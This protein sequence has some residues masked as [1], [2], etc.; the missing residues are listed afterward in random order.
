MTNWK[1][2]TLTTPRLL[3]RPW[4]DSDAE[5]LYRFASDPQV[6][7]AAGWPPHTSIENSREII[8]GVLS[9]RETYAMILRYDTHDTIN[10]EIIPAGTPVGSVGIMFKGCGSYPRLRDNEAEIGYWVARPL[11]G[12]ELAPEAVWAIMGRCFEELGLERLW[13]GF[14]EGNQ[15]SRRVQQ[16]C[17]FLTE[18]YLGIPP[19]PLNGATV[20]Y[21]TSVNRYRWQDMNARPPATMDMTLREAPFR[22]VASGQKRVELRLYDCKRRLLRV[23]DF[24]HF[25]LEEGQESCHVEVTGIRYF[26]SFEALYAELLPAMGAA[27]LGYAEGEIPHPDDMLAYYTRESINFHGVVAI[28][29]K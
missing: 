14:Y 9:A 18:T 13:C 20:E 19:H 24:I 23:G 11:W 29:I 25:R 12:R 1:H 16:K 28:E 15:S 6:G 7:P 17:G 4:Q 2:I 26:P 27:A 10:G 22:A 8:R 5:A 21:F 3:L